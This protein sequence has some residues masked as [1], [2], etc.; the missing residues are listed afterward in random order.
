MKKDSLKQVA[1]DTTKGM[2]VK[3]KISTAE[4]ME[5]LALIIRQ[6]IGREIL[7]GHQ[8]DGNGGAK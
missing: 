7:E 1:K 8:D 5:R 4:D 6:T 3:Q 2:T